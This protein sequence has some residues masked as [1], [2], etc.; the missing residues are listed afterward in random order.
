MINIKKIK[1]LKNAMGG[2]CKVS[3]T[4]SK[5]YGLEIFIKSE[6]DSR[7]YKLSYS[8]ECFRGGIFI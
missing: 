7:S 4:R 8:T 1:K 3:V 2:D 6:H 5:N